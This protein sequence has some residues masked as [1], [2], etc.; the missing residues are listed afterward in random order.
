M[1]LVQQI[2]AIVEQMPEKN[3]ML[4]LELIKT[5]IATDDILTDEDEM[6]I[7]KARMEFMQGDFVRHQDIDWS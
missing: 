1:S 2:H 3:Q 7:K 5:M 4:I 6:D